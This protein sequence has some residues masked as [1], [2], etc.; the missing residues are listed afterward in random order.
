MNNQNYSFKK[1]E[2]LF[3]MAKIGLIFAVNN[4]LI[5]FWVELS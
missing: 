1:A 3:G 4:F 2:N 5:F